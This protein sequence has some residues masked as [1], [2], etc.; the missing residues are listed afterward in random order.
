MVEVT[1]IIPTYM[2]EKYIQKCMESVINQNFEK[3]KMEIFIVDGNSTDS[4]IPI[5]KA[6]EE[7]Y[8]RLVKLLIN[9]KKTQAY[10]MN[11]GIGASHGKYI[12]R[13]DAHAEYRNDYIQKCVYYLDKTG[14]TNVGGVAITKGKGKNGQIIAKMLSGK[15][16]VGNSQFRING[17][18]GFVD[19][20]PFGA[21]RKT[22]FNKYGGFDT[23]FERNE[24][25]EINYRIRKN[26]GKV[27][28]ANDIRFIYYCR[29]TVNG[30]LKMAFQNGMWNVYSIKIIPGSM[31]VRHFVP[32]L[33]VL[34]LLS[35][36][37]LGIN[38]KLFR[39]MLLFELIIYFIMDF[40][41]S[42]KLSNKMSEVCKLLFLHFAFHVSYG[43][44][45][46]FGLFKL[47]KY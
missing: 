40:F 27:Y 9:I 10:A 18:S 1:I 30:I 24:D 37:I 13:M 20:V 41:C 34:S 14:A 32:L 16:G 21:F 2:E 43:F 46:V 38:I 31:G 33:F 44:G 39:M 22:F 4:T 8:P 23:R 19:T 45:S 12:L 26:G 36:F 7:K 17:K 47:I 15:F 3:E 28:L 42:S 29:D 35:L 11:I 5:V 25:N 6:Y